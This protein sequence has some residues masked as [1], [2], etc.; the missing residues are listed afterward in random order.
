MTGKITVSVLKSFRKAVKKLYS[1]SEIKELAKFLAYNPESGPIIP[2]TGGLRK[3][4]WAL[5]G[6]GKRGGSR[7]IYYYYTSKSEILLLTAY[8]KNEK[9][10]LT[11]KDKKLLKELVKDV[12]EQ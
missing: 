3:M 1:E 7:V 12:L 10:D 5:S 8:A 4:R 11:E 9:E 6:K 2:G